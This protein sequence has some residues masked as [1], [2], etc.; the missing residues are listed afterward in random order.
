MRIKV[1]FLLFGGILVCLQSAAIAQNG[2]VNSIFHQGVGARQS[3]LGGAVVAYPQDPTTIY[4]NPAGLEY[5]P[6]KS[7]SLYYTTFLGGTSYQFVGFAFPTL[8]NGTFGAG[9]TRIS[10]DGIIEQGSTYLQNGLGEF[11]SNQSEF[12]LSGAKIIRNLISVGVNIKLQHHSINGLSDTGIGGDLSFMYLPEFDNS[13]LRNIRL[14]LN[15]QNLVSPILNPGDASDKIPTRLLFGFAKPFYLGFDRNP[16][17]LLFSLDQNKQQSMGYHTGLEYTYLDKGMVRFG[18]D[19]NG[20][21]FGAGTLYKRIQIDYTYGKLTESAFGDS[22]KLSFSI[23]FGKSREELLQIAERKRNLEIASQVELGL[24]QERQNTIDRLLIEG[25][26]IYSNASTV[27]EYMDAIIKFSQVLDLDSNNAEAEE[28]LA[29]SDKRT[30]ELRL[31]EQQ[32]ILSAIEDSRVQKETMRTQ[33][34]IDSLT[35]LGQ[36]LFKSSEYNAAI[37]QWDKVLAE[38]PDDQLVKDMI[39]SAQSELTKNVDNLIRRAD[40]MAKNQDYAGAITVLAGVQLLSLGNEEALR[41]LSI[42]ING[43]ERLLNVSSYYQSGL[44]AYTEEKWVEALNNFTKANRINSNYMNLKHYYT[45]AERR[46]NAKDMAMTPEMVTKYKQGYDLYLEVRLQ[47]AI[48][49]W[50]ELLIEQHYNKLIIELI[51]NANKQL[52]KQKNINR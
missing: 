41:Q 8:Y 31:A 3:A 40:N 18:L 25:R 39:A 12:Y 38:R 35:N 48:D 32:K 9:V 11:S 36:S 27:L 37:E 52:E 5:L 46:V 34:R 33:A 29:E 43:L 49:I 23:N 4:W 22:H 7:I 44:I 26:Q 15:V 21:A 20:F 47:E 2:G 10:A 45:E 51:D 42:K 14:G 1:S 24:D 30:S 16:L 17:V 13:L 28:R 6:E 50:E 19:Q